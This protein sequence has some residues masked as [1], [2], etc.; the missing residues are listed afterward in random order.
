LLLRGLLLVASNTVVR[1][2]TSFL[3]LNLPNFVILSEAKDLLFFGARDSRSFAA[4]RMTIQ[5]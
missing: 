5:E 2:R 4:L 1:K 3:T